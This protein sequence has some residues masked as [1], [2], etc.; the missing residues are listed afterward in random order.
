MAVYHSRNPETSRMLE[1]SVSTELD[2][3]FFSGGEDVN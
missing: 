3:I 2:I 1:S